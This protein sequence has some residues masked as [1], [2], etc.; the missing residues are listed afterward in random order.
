MK[1]THQPQ[2]RQQVFD[3]LGIGFGPANIALA[4]ALEEMA[5][6]LSVQFLERRGGP[7]WQE[8]ML[9]EHSDIQNHPLRDLVTPRD[10]RSRYTFT[11]FL[12]ENGR[13][14][15]HLNLGI[16]YPLRVEYEQ[17]IRWVAE[18]FSGQVQYGCEVV[19]ILPLF[20]RGAI[21][22]YAVTDA[23]GRVWRAR[24]LVVAP[25]RT[26]NIPPPFQDVRDGRIV[27]LNDYLFAL[28]RAGEGGRKSRVAVAGGSQSAVEILLHASGSGACASVTGI[29]RNF[30]FRQKDTSPFSDEVYFP[31][32]VRTFYHADR[33]TKARLRA[34]L[35]STNYSSADKDVVDALYLKLYTGRILGR[36]GL[37]VLTNTSVT[38]AEPGADGVRLALHNSVTGG[39]LHREF[40]LVVLATGFLDIG[41]G[42]K[43]EPYPKLLAP[44]APLMALDGGHLNVRFD[45]RVMYGGGHD[46]GAPLYLNGLCES[47][48]GMGDSGSFSLLALRCAAIAGS[49][50]ERLEMTEENHGDTVDIVPAAC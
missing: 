6:H 3:V 32:F 10:P 29:T 36:D 39:T 18:F 26:P 44:L 19:E 14:F 12:F 13:L 50:R 4:I 49:L 27:H 25:G 9:L 22:G 42:P 37:A 30:G 20:E 41:T 2:V 35:E 17:Y 7:G 47:S 21:A 34:E 11:N 1:T 16:A 28:G 5:P 43:R 31:S 8:G 24:S 45:Y 48:H 33:H 15:E 40:D 46:G 23:G 38:A